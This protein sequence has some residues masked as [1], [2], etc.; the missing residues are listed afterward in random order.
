VSSAIARPPSRHLT[1]SG[2]PTTRSQ[3]QRPPSS[4]PDQ[5]L[6][7]RATPGGTDGRAFALP[8]F[9]IFER[10]FARIRCPDCATE[11]L[12]AFPCKGRGLCPSCGTKRAA[13]FAAF[14]QDEVVSE[15][16]ILFLR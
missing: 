13:E 14:L 11:G 5:E 6:A 10:G 7:L 15:P 4:F 9:G 16:W 1:P 2:Q 8:S 3:V 12:L